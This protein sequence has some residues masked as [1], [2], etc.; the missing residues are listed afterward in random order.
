M[1]PINK[2]D[3]DAMLETFRVMSSPGMIEKI[4]A[5]ENGKPEDFISLE[6]FTAMAE[7]EKRTE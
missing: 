3:H 4:E 7:D 6:E 1:S 2:K 5:A